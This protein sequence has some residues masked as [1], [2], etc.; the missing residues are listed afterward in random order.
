MNIKTNYKKGYVNSVLNIVFRYGTLPYDVFQLYGKTKAVQYHRAVKK[1]KDEGILEEIKTLNKVRCI[2][3]S[4]SVPEEALRVID[5][6]ISSNNNK[7]RLY[8]LAMKNTSRDNLGRY[9]TD[10]TKIINDISAEC[11]V[12]AAG[13]HTDAMLEDMQSIDKPLYLTS[14]QLKKESDYSDK[15]ERTKEGADSLR[16]SRINGLYAAPGGVFS[17]YSLGYHLIEWRRSGEERMQAYVAS[18]LSN[19]LSQFYISMYKKE[20]IIL[21][22]SEVSFAEIVKLD[23]SPKKRMTGRVLM[24][25]DYAYE[26]MYAIPYN[27]NGIKMFQMM[28]TQNWKY[29]LKSKFLCHEEIEEA[30]FVSIRCDGYDKDTGVYTLVFCIPDMTKLKDFLKRATLEEDSSK[31]RIIC[32][33]HQLPMLAEIIGKNAKIMT[34]SLDDVY[35]EVM[36][37]NEEY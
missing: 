35:E 22:K 29:Q 33:K 15:I 25:I 9:K 13:F 20:A 30:G 1:L 24:N 23:Y 37:E 5:A 14:T 31:F 17:I 34:I 27:P 12:E 3:F 21:S 26:S 10:Q 8:M 6:T 32:Y 2:R 4:D 18:M 19:R 28:Q 7:D 16:N 36:R 11:F